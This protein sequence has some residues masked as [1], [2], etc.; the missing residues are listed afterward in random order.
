MGCV[1]ARLDQLRQDFPGVIRAIQLPIRNAEHEQKLDIGLFPVLKRTKL[2]DR[3]VEF[4]HV[5][6]KYS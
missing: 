1:A 4:V 2:A 6:S 5:W 3:A